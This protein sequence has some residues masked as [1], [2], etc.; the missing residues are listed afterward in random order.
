MQN[1]RKY[2]S[3]LCFNLHT[4]GAVI[5]DHERAYAELKHLTDFIGIVTEL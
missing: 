4:K 5:L 2:Y 3:F 1:K